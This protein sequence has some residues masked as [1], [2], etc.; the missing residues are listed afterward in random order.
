MSSDRSRRMVV[1]GGAG[2]VGEDWGGTQQLKGCA[3]HVTVVRLPGVYRDVKA[4][5]VVC[6]KHV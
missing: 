2:G 5:Q 4:Y 6:F 3:R 1:W